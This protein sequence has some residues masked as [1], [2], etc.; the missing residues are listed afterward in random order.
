M[1]DLGGLG[2]RYRTM[3]PRRKMPKIISKIRKSYA[4]LQK[5]NWPTLVLLYKYPRYL[6]ILWTL[7]NAQYMYS[8]TVPES[9]AIW[10]RSRAVHVLHS[11]GIVHVLLNYLECY[12]SRT[13]MCELRDVIGVHNRPMCGVCGVC[14]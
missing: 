2:I 10:L 9:N 4:I 1:G 5:L 7:C 8:F 6:N 12:L 14:A 11:I 3:V 13:C